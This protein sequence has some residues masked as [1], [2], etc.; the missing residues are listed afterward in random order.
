MFS[1]YPFQNVYNPHK[2]Y[3]FFLF[4]YFFLD[5]VLV[6]GQQTA[7]GISTMA[8]VNMAPMSPKTS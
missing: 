1:V 6:G 7:L 2:I 8:T 5:K 4:S 3:Y